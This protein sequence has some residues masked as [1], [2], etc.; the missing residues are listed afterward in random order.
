ME[1]FR[2]TR[3]TY[4]NDL[5]GMGA[6][7]Y[8]A[9]W[10]HKQHA[11]LYTASSRSLAMLETIVHLEKSQF[12][13]D[14]CVMVIYVPDTVIM[15]QFS[16]REL[17]NDWR[18]QEMYT[19]EV[20]TQWLT[21]QESLVLRVPSVLVKAEYNYLLNPAHMAFNDIKLIDIEPIEFDERFFQKR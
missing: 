9:R 13:D 6:Y 19:K 21:A 8:G 16:D 12:L 5:S 17:P 2:L 11:M 1:L 7:K 3:R 18:V 15:R 14:H 20:G 10:N 4:Q